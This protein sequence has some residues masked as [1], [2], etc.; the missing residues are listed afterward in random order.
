MSHN[1]LSFDQGSETCYRLCALPVASARREATIKL[2]RPVEDSNHLALADSGG[3]L[4]VLHVP[5]QAVTSLYQVYR[6]S[7]LED[8]V[9]EEGSEAEDADTL[10]AQIKPPK[11]C[12]LPWTDF[13]FVPG[14]KNSL[15]LL[16]GETNTVMCTSLPP[17]LDPEDMKAQAPRA[18]A[19]FAYGVPLVALDQGFTPAAAGIEGRQTSARIR[20]IAVDSTGSVLASGNDDGCLRVWAL[21]GRPSSGLAA[22]TAS[23]ARPSRVTP[24]AKGNVVDVLRAHA[25]PIWRVAHGEALA[26]EEGH[27]VTGGGDRA[28]RVWAWAVSEWGAVQVQPLHTLL[29][30][31]CTVRSLAAGAG[32][33]LILAGSNR[34][35]LYCWSSLTA[36]LEYVAV[37]GDEPVVALAAFAAEGEGGEGEYTGG[38]EA[39]VI[40]T[41]DAL[42]I[43]RLYRP[44]A[45]SQSGE[46]RVKG[47]EEGDIYTNRE[48][49][50]ETD[51]DIDIWQ[52][53][54]ESRLD[55]SAVA[56]FFL[57]TE[58]S[59]AGETA[60]C[61]VVV[62][63]S[64]MVLP[65][66]VASLP[67]FP[68]DDR[69]L[70]SPRPDLSRAE[71]E[72]ALGEEREAARA[73]GGEGRALSPSG[74]GGE[75]EEASRQGPPPSPS[76]SDA[77]TL[78][79]AFT[80]LRTWRRDT[81]TLARGWQ[82]CEL[83]LPALNSTALL[84]DALAQAE[85]ARFSPGGMDLETPSVLEDAARA[86]DVHPLY[87]VYPDVA[88]RDAYELPP[89][90]PVPK[91][92][93][94]RWR[95]K[96]MRRPTALDFFTPDLEGVMGG[97]GESG[98][99]GE[100]GEEIGR[101]GG[102]GERGMPIQTRGFLGGQGGLMAT[103]FA[104][105]YR[106]PF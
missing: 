1:L 33:G 67:R 76:A 84:R 106:G 100:E 89:P 63:S 28:V 8:E 90:T 29:T 53:V 77:A 74:G 88:P 62:S 35:T 42:G 12:P 24:P 96:Q 37:G 102:K 40:A 72:T 30:E 52:P 56:A 70:P 68:G 59:R 79:E 10:R 3:C 99:G 49:E 18:S 36:A 21:T 83:G 25:G 20:T 26:R 78:L 13:A 9:D 80:N 51:E 94:P 5:T 19:S 66:P 43:V 69:R 4:R 22:Q 61:L 95:A 81:Q 44:R 7:F 86:V 87:R 98:G 17:Q 105:L 2:A 32:M 75:G 47:L 64:G 91:A 73:E 31:T 85:Q 71:A 39:S 16:L 60:P 23:G 14:R 104:A 92:T 58:G 57:R 15:F 11:P 41:A 48:E 101:E 27:V 55:A 38:G 82:P 65:W 46:A 45:W 54:A 50:R 6:G 97:G 93:D 103:P 34:G